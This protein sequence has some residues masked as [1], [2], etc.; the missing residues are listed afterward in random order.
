M[1]GLREEM[2]GEYIALGSKGDLKRRQD[3]APDESETCSASG[4]AVTLL[5]RVSSSH[6]VKLLDPAS[7]CPLIG[8]PGRTSAPSEMELTISHDPDQ[9]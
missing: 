8:F 3:T 4:R 2:E 7:D 6:S 5:A 1:L 9:N